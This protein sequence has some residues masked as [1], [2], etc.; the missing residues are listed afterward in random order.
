LSYKIALGFTKAAGDLTKLAGYESSLDRKLHRALSE[1]QRLQD[2]RKAEEAAT[3]EVID[4]T[5]LNT[6]A[7]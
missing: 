2:A 7:G 4:V 5:D 6:E 3:A 1:F